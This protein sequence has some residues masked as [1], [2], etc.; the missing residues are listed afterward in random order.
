MVTAA[1]PHAGDAKT[2]RLDVSV[3]TLAHV[4]AAFLF[5]FLGLLLAVGIL[6]KVSGSP[7]PLL[8]RY[9]V[10][11]AVTVGQGTLGFVQYWTGVPEVLVSFHVLGAMLVIIATAT[12]WCATAVREHIPAGHDQRWWRAGEQTSSVKVPT[13]T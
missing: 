13:V 2:P 5:V 11:A 9:A 1:G 12:M 8:V 6:L 7:R 4:H 10:L 3:D